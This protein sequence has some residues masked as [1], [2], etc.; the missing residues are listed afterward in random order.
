MSRPLLS[1]AI[2]RSNWERKR[3]DRIENFVP[4][5][6]SLLLRKNYENVD[7]DQLT[8]LRIDFQEEYGLSVPTHAL[9]SILKRMTKNGCLTKAQNT[10]VVEKETI[11][12]LDISLKSTEIEREFNYLLNTIKNFIKRTTEEEIEE[13]EI[14][15]ALIAFLKDHDLDILFASRNRSLLPKVSA[16]KKVGYLIGT[17]IQHA[18]QNDPTSFKYLVDVAIGHA[19]SATLLYEHFEVFQGKL[20]D[21]EI[22]FDT[23]WIFE[24]LGI[25]GKAKQEMAI[26]LLELLK[27][28]DAKLRILDI[29]KGELRTNLEICKKDFERAKND[30]AGHTYSDCL[31]YGI[32]ET[33]IERLIMK[34]DEILLAYGIQENQVSDYNANKVYQIDDNELYDTIILTYEER[35]G[36]NSENQKKEGKEGEKAEEDRTNNTV[37]RDV[38]SLS[39]MYRSRMGVMPKSLKECKALFVTTNSSLALASRRFE[40][41][42]NKTNHT[43]PTCVTDSF[44]GTIIWLATPAK[45]QNVAEKKLIA[46]SYALIEPSDELI[47]KYL[48]ELEKL[49]TQKVITDDEYILLRT[50]KGAFSI[51]NSVT[52]GELGEFGKDTPQ[53]ILAQ[54]VKSFEIDA[55]MA[56]QNKLDES[57]RKIEQAE[58]DKQAEQ[59][60]HGETKSELN[61]FKNIVDAVSKNLHGLIRLIVYTALGLLTIFLGYIIYG[62]QTGA[63]VQNPALSCLLTIVVSALTVA[64]LVFGFY[65]TEYIPKLIR[66]IT[67]W[68]ENRLFRNG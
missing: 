7:G 53:E 64:N 22:H 28:E 60:K 27:A 44:L 62:L 51:L 63:F 6:G 26:E 19:L 66:T 42:H 50:Y 25:K 67:N 9:V 4:L 3:K 40:K 35:R 68:V 48:D 1:L 11:S 55:K 49:K 5:V 54:V 31:L 32:T 23:P 46:D 21:V 14:E 12:K 36:S 65:F 47:T 56:V 18:H 17:F 30:K 24:L 41:K 2:V 57:K 59:V 16:S 8:R 33:D 13:K 10:W 61:Q 45:A 58:S 34:L 37:W 39:G 15:K 20:K 43:I 38:D 29:N 52:Y